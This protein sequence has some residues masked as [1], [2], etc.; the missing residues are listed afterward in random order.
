MGDVLDVRFID[1]GG[2]PFM[3]IGDQR[4]G[5]GKAAGGG[6]KDQLFHG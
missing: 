6:G 5:Q 2:V 4:R 3:G 1:F